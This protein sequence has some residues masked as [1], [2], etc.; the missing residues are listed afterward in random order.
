M[1]EKWVIAMRTWWLPCNWRLFTEWEKSI[2]L[3]IRLWVVQ[4]CGLIKTTEEQKTASHSEWGFIRNEEKYF[5]HSPKLSACKQCAPRQKDLPGMEIFKL[6]IAHIN[7]KEADYKHLI[8][9]D[10]TTALASYT[11]LFSISISVQWVSEATER[12]W[13]I[14]IKTSI[15]CFYLFKI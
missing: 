4:L 14:L 8:F 11:K 15:F 5:F 13:P 12:N 6:L 9:S 7:P 1:I 10:V 2:L 3:G